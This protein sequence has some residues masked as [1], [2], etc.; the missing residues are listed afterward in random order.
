MQN[1]RIKEIDLV[2]NKK[3]GMIKDQENKWVYSNIKFH[4]I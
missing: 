3:N 2:K 4:N 1:R